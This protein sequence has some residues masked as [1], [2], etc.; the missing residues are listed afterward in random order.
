MLD[1]LDHLP[2]FLDIIAVRY[3]KHILFTLA[4]FENLRF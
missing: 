1:S 2:E 4:L 3:A